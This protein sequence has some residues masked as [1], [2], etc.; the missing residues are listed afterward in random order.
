MARQDQPPLA[1]ALLA[2]PSS[3]PDS[4][5]LQS[6]STLAGVRPEMKSHPRPLVASP[7]APPHGHH[8]NLAVGRH[9]RHPHYLVRSLLRLPAFAILR[10]LTRAFRLE[11]SKHHEA[12][13]CH[14][15]LPRPWNTPAWGQYSS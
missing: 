12:Q 5:A 2:R 9:H 1:R 6:T 3:L 10:L 13:Q 8:D 4:P 7:A 15:A 11:Y 14:Q